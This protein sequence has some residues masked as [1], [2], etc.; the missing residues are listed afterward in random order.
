MGDEAPGIDLLGGQILMPFTTLTKMVT[1]SLQ[2]M[3]RFWVGVG[4]NQDGMRR[5]A[6]RHGTWWIFTMITV[7]SFYR[8]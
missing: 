2:W 8:S 1:S 3:R 6:F 4:F 5:G 7:Y